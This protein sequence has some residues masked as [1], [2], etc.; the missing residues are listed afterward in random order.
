MRLLFLLVLLAN[1]ALFTW[2]WFFH[3]GS[4]GGRIAPEPPPGTLQLEGTST[5]SAKDPRGQCFELAGLVDQHQAARVQADLQQRGLPV[6]AVLAQTMEPLGYWVFLPP[7]DSLE[8][9]QA[10]AQQLSDDGVDDYVFVVGSKKANAISLGVFPTQAEAEQR[11]RRIA[12]LGYDPVVEKRFRPRRS[13]TL[14]VRGLRAQ[15]PSPPE[16]SKWSPADC[17]GQGF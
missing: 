8:D 16:P 1:I 6:H 17:Q 12:Q 4:T 10:V 15:L 14:T 2:G 9:A 11:Q 5:S 13:V 7:A 3:S